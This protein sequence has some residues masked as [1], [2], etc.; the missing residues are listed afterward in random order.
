MM[1]SLWYGDSA[2]HNQKLEHHL[3]GAR[4]EVY[5]HNPNLV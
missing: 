1:K 2:K 3:G 5:F 4:A